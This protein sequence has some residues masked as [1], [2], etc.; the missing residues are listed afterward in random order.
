[1]DN[2]RLTSKSL[3]VANKLL[4]PAIDHIKMVN[5]MTDK[6]K[7]EYIKAKYNLTHGKGKR[8]KRKKK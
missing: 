7:I 1:M 3:S 6:E 4:T 5:S 8:K 2:I